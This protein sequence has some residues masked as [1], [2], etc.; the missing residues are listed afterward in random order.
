MCVVSVVWTPL[1]LIVSTKTFKMSPF[2]F[3]RRKE[4]TDF[5]MSVLDVRV[6]K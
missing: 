3:H 2:V 5:K 6:S 1:T 4:V